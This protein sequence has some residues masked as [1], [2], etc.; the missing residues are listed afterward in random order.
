M[1]EDQH[2]FRPRDETGLEAESVVAACSCGWTGGSYPVE[3]Q[4]LEEARDEFDDHVT[5]LL[6]E[7]DQPP[8]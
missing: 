3:D 8:T 4:G 5:G 1:N 6:L 7:Q 2:E